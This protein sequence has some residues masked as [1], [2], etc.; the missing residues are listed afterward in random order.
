MVRGVEEREV[1]VDGQKSTSICLIACSIKINLICSYHIK[2]QTTCAQ[3]RERIGV[4]KDGTLD[5]RCH[6]LVD[7]DTKGERKGEKGGRGK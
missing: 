1:C 7:V 3:C 2:L 5:R 4:Y 6:G